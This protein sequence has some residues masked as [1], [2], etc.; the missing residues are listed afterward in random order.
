VDLVLDTAQQRLNETYRAH[1]KTGRIRQQNEANIIKAAEVEFAQ[2]GFKGTSLNAVADRAGLPKSNILYYFKSKLGLYGAVLADILDMWNEA[3]SD[4]D[5][6]SDPA[7]T[8]YHYIESKVQYSS[9][10]PLASR[11]FAMEIIM[12]APHLKEFLAT[13]LKTWAEGRS[14][15]IQSWIDAGKITDVHPIHL[16]FLIWGGTQHYA[17]FSTQVSWILG[18]DACDEQD[19]KDAT[20]TISKIVLGGLGLKMPIIES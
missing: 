11:I 2:N 19:F 10:H 16:I 13:D 20:N 6:H 3:F 15:V 17:D 9:S 12:G 8:L 1:K 7:H 4:A 18:K 5:E 14:K